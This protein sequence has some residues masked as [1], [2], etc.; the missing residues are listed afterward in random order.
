[1]EFKLLKSGPK[2]FAEKKKLTS[3]TRLLNGF[4]SLTCQSEKR[5]FSWLSST[6]SQV[7]KFFRLFSIFLNKFFRVYTISQAS[8]CK[9]YM[10]MLIYIVPSE[11]TRILTR[12]C[13]IKYSIFLIQ[14]KKVIDIFYFL[15][16]VTFLRSAN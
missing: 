5:L 6:R 1:M 9:N 14:Q 12:Y 3:S 4:K 10:A 8:C 16:F 7:N 2:K 15:N 11:Y 13:M